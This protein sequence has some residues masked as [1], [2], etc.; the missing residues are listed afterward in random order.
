MTE[1]LVIGYGNRLRS[2]DAVGPLVAEAVSRLHRPGVEALALAQLTP[3]LSEP[4]SR[5]RL[6]LFVDG[7]I[8]SDAVLIQPLAP[9]P[10][11]PSL[12]HTGDPRWL[13]GLTLA[14]YGQCPV[15]WLIAVPV[16]HLDFG[17]QLSAAALQGVDI[18]LCEID[19]L[20]SELS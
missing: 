3:E 8:D 9:G 10:F 2:D 15:S 20:L 17:E 7:C 16:V 12:H 19:R 6:A 13:L 11:E 18:A 4:L 14:V 5:V 1:V